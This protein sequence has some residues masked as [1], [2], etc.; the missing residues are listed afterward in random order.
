MLYRNFLTK[1]INMEGGLLAENGMFMKFVVGSGFDYI[2]EVGDDFVVVDVHGYRLS[3]SLSIFV[4]QERL[5][6]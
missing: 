6:P 5:T 1:Y 3:F 4:L 2:R